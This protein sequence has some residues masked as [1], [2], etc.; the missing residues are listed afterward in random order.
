MLT[1]MNLLDSKLK[2]SNV[3]LSLS[4]IKVFLKFCISN[5][6]L[7]GT[8]FERIKNTLI[9]LLISSTNEMRYNVLVQINGLLAFGDTSV[10]E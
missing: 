4:V 10:F 9:T 1:I 5:S 6:K 7:F 2:S 3:N 8:V